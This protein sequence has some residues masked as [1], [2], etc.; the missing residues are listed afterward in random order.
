MRLNYLNANSFYNG[1][2]TLKF[3][4]RNDIHIHLAFPLPSKALQEIIVI[5][6]RLHLAQQII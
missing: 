6:V 1:T 5:T 2:Y 3:F 4:Q